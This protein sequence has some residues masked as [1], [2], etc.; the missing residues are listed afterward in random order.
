MRGGRRE[1]KRRLLG[2]RSLCILSHVKQNTE[3]NVFQCYSY[4]I[5]LQYVYHAHWSAITNDNVL[6]VPL[7]LSPLERTLSPVLPY[8]ETKKNTTQIIY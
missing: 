3:D 4:F 6:C 7:S 5:Q 8:G 1:K 2:G